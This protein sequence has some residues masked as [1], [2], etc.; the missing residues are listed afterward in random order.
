MVSRTVTSQGDDVAKEASPSAIL[1]A[2]GALAGS[3]SD[4]ARSEK[5]EGS[6]A[7]AT[8]SAQAPLAQGETVDGEAERTDPRREARKGGVG[9]ATIDQAA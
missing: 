6:E 7:G 8:R 3:T 5:A 2:A 1:S 9:E 4:A